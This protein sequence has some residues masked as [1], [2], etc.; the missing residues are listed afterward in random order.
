MARL[1]PM[2]CVVAL[3]CAW[4]ESHPARVPADA[5]ATTKVASDAGVVFPAP[6]PPL[7]GPD[8]KSLRLERSIAVRFEPTVDSK[9]LGTV[10]AHTRVGFKSARRAPGCSKRW[11][12]LSP[13]GWVCEIYLEPSKKPPHGV[14]LPKLGWDELVPG[15]YGKVTA[16][17]AKTFKFG[18]GQ[19]VVA[20]QLVGSATVRRYGGIE[21]DGKAYWAIGGGEYL[22]ES[23]IRRHQPTS[24][25]GVRL[26]DET[27]RSLPQA[28][29]VAHKNAIHRVPVYSK[30]VGGAQVRRLI[31]RTPVDIFETASAPDGTPQAYRI[32]DDQWLRAEDVR[33]ARASDPPPTTQDTERWFDVDVDSQVLVA[34]E[35]RTPVYAT[36]ISSGRRRTPTPTGIY[37][38]WVKFAETDMN[39]Q[40]GDE[41]AYSVATVPWT[42]FY[43]K[44]FA[45]H[46]AYWHDNF[47]NQRSHGCINLAPA[48]A[49]Y[50]YFWSSP[51]VPPG[52]SMAH[53]VFERPGSMVRVRGAADPQPAFQGY[54]RR[55]YE[56]RLSA[57]SDTVAR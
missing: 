56:S 8:I 35:G 25:S 57:D 52:W 40:M 20:R 49:H 21:L 39:G 36:M 10:A 13:R 50:L 16:E 5:T 45:L 6:E 1:V 51:D 2:L 4:G 55:V 31:R 32:A 44:D 26:G 41:A 15:A 53:G 23:A 12:E 3:G 7:F 24:W 17:G 47:G 37:R 28:F 42:Q 29:A 27:G 14:E 19:L 11:I 48:D 54:A 33:I 18:D 9:K 34:Y 46:T 22:A 43:A 30:P 38:I